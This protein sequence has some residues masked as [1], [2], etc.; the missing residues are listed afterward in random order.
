[1][2]IATKEKIKFNEFMAIC[3]EDGVYEW[4]NGEIV[5]MATTRNH[6]D[7]LNLPTDSL[8]ESSIA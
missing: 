6:D 5:K 3:P 8:I 1:M 4:V 7:V 2:T